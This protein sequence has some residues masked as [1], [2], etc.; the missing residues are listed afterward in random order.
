M[1]VGNILIDGLSEQYSVLDIE[2]TGRVN[3]HAICEVKLRA[4]EKTANVLSGFQN[5]I[6]KEF[7]S[8]EILFLGKLESV[9]TNHNLEVVMRLI[10]N[11]VLFDLKKRKQLFRMFL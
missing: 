11:S 1:D 9:T 2:I 8:S 6:I 5:I 7:E 4:N 10:S 3:E